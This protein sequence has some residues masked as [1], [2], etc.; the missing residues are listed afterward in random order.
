MLYAICFLL[1][2]KEYSAVLRFQLAAFLSEGDI[3]KYETVGAILNAYTD[4]REDAFVS[5]CYC[6][7]QELYDQA[8]VTPEQVEALRNLTKDNIWFQYLL[9]SF[10][11][12]VGWIDFE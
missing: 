8:P 3:Q 6:S 5:T 7:H 1:F 2:P 10:N 4:S 12:D 11:K 9:K